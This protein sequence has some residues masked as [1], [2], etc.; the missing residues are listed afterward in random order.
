MGRGLSDMGEWGMCW[1]YL[2]C[3]GRPGV[4]FEGQ[5]SSRK[6]ERQWTDVAGRYTVDGMSEGL[7][8]RNG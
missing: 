1:G 2:G 3:C 6:E 8:E 7:G 5:L 4:R